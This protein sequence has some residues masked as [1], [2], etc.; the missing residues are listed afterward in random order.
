MS[1][2]ERIRIGD[3]ERESAMSALSDHLSAGRLD[4]DE[5]GE[6]TAKVTA[7]RTRSDLSVL[8]DDLPDPKPRFETAGPPAVAEPATTA[9]ET[10]QPPGSPAQRAAAGGMGLAWIA[11]GALAWYTDLWILLVIPLALS[12]V[13]GS[14]W[15]SGWRRDLRDHDRDRD[16]RWDHRHG[17]YDH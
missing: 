4:I 13:F 1:T 15:G 6:R 5:Y 11:C 16:R 17:R 7:A 10:R 9:V 3:S 8:F 12:V 14:V 2:D